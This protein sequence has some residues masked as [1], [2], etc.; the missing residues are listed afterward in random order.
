MGLNEQKRRDGK[1]SPRFKATIQ[2]RRV[3]NV[4]FSRRKQWVI[5][6]TIF[7]FYPCR[8]PT[9]VTVHTLMEKRVNGSLL[10]KHTD[11]QKKAK[12]WF[13]FEVIQK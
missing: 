11:K 10:L 12:H 7:F 6:L 1:Q 3:Q 4:Q 9:I 5:V 8:H 13:N 2:K